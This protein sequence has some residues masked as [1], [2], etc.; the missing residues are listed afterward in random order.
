MAGQM[1]HLEL[2]AGDT[3]KAREFWTCPG[4]RPWDMS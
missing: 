1:V 3:A 4:D 2:P